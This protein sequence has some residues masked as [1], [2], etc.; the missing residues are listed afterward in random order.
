MVCIFWS[1][2]QQKGVNISKKEYKHAKNEKLKS[3]VKLGYEHR[4][5]RKREAQAGEG[6]RASDAYHSSPSSS[7]APNTLHGSEEDRKIYEKNV[8]VSFERSHKC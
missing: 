3:R 6:V 5:K 1:D 4:T 7:P 2:H 8:P